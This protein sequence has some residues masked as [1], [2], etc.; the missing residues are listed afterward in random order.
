MSA[1]KTG[2]CLVHRRIEPIVARGLCASAYKAAA[3]RGVLEDYPKHRRTS[4][5]VIAD[6]ERLRGQGLPWAVVARRLG[7]ASPKVA[8]NVYRTACVYLG[9]PYPKCRRPAA[10]LIAEADALKAQ[11]LTRRQIAARLGYT[12]ADS[13]ARTYRQAT[14]QLTGVKP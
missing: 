2:I 7:Y 3:A 9:R 13:Y 1:R 5:Q 10:E 12:S 14:R 11:G 4:A 8:R 6:C